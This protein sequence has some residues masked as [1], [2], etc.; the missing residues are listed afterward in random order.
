MYRQDLPF[1]HL[2]GDDSHNVR[3]PHVQTLLYDLTR[4]RGE[5]FISA[6]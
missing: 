3:S 1:L 6:A 4:I 2:G 5:G